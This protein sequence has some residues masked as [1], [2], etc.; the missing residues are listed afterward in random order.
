MTIMKVKGRYPAWREEDIIQ[1]RLN[2]WLWGLFLELVKIIETVFDGIDYDDI[3][4]KLFNDEKAAEYLNSVLG[5]KDIGKIAA[6]CQKCPPAG[7]PGK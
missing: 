7:R 1:Y 5:N 3:I 2:E 4:K 6:Q